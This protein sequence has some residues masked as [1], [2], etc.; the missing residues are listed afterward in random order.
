MKNIFKIQRTLSHY[1]ETFV[2]WKDS[3]DV[4]GS[5]WSQKNNNKEP[6]RVQV[7]KCMRVSKWR[8][9]SYFGVNYPFNRQK[10]LM[11][12]WF[13]TSILNLCFHTSMLKSMYIS[14]FI[15]RAVQMVAVIH[16]QNYAPAREEKTYF[17]PLILHTWLAAGFPFYCRFFTAIK[18][19]SL[20]LS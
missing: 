5:S 1:K 14:H 12:W 15:T 20:W 7:W 8:H 18:G 9:N 16:M 11:F 13:Q 4:K 3:M 10:Q 2:E 19:F 17:F 6:V